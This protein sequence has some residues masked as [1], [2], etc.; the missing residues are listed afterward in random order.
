MR[1]IPH[2]EWRKAN[3]N[4]K[5]LFIAGVRAIV[6]RSREAP[7]AGLVAVALRDEGI[8]EGGAL[9]VL[10]ATREPGYTLRL[11]QSG[12]GG[13]L[14]H[15][16]VLSVLYAR[17]VAELHLEHEVAQRLGLEARPIQRRLELEPE[18][19]AL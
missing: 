8:V 17:G 18:D 6:V 12:G 11:R 16:D 4:G 2:T 7:P 10:A 19:G 9:S 13:R 1:M 5:R 3:L 14:D 15:R